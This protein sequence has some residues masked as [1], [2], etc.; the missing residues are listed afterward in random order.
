[1]NVIFNILFL[2]IT[3]GVALYGEYHLFLNHPAW[4]ALTAFFGMASIAVPLIFKFILKWELP[5]CD[6]WKNYSDRDYWKI[7]IGIIACFAISAVLTLIR[8]AEYRIMYSG[9]I[10]IL[11]AG[12]IYQ[13][14]MVQKRTKEKASVPESSESEK[15]DSLRGTNG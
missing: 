12:G 1:M 15:K 8:G 11:A 4:L 14:A 6:G 3:S 2:M 13:F 7:P 9:I 5:H 10:F